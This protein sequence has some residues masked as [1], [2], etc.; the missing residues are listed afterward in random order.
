MSYLQTAAENTTKKYDPYDP[1]VDEAPLEAH[2]YL[3]LAHHLKYE[4]D[5]AIGKFEFLVDELPPKHQ[6]HQRSLRQIEMC[7]EAKDQIAK[8]P[9]IM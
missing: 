1:T 9:R 3:G 4:M 6:L 7:N 8:L 2:Y 5:I